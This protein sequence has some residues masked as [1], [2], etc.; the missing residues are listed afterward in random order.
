MC[1]RKVGE[2]VKRGAGDGGGREKEEGGMGV[3]DVRS[4]RAL[5]QQ[6]RW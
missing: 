5:S 2:G 4:E 3:V 6:V 1:G